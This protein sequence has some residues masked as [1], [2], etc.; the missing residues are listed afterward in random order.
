MLSGRTIYRLLKKGKWRCLVGDIPVH[1]QDLKINP[2]SVNVTLGNI[3]IKVTPTNSDGIIDLHD[4]SSFSGEKFEFEELVIYPG[5]FYLLHIQE[6]FECSKPLWTWLGRKYYAPMIHGRSTSARASLSI[7]ETAGFGD[8][9]FN[10]AFTLEASTKIAV[11]LRPGDMIAQV[12]FEETDSPYPR[13]DSVYN[14]QHYGPKPPVLGKR[15]F[16]P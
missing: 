8:Y 13:Y 2:N 3:A 6:R 7:H 5:E 10:S 15:R 9:G 14:N 11:R 1:H 4:P 12:A 16:Q